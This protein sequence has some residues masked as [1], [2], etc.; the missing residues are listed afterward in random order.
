MLS[1]LFLPIMLAPGV[2]LYF[3]MFH[4]P[5]A[6]FWIDRSTVLG[7]PTQVMILAGILFPFVL[8]LW[9]FWSGNWRRPVLTAAFVYGTCFVFG[10][11]GLV[12]SYTPPE[13]RMINLYGTKGIDV[14]CNGVHLG[15]LPLKI[16]VEE[17]MAKVP[18]WT[19]PPEQRWYSDADHNQRRTTW[20]P[21]DDFRKE[22]FE[23]S[24]E[25][26]ATTG[27]RNTSNT[28]RAI[29]ARQEALNKHDAECRY[30]WSYRSGDTQMAFLRSENAYYFN[31]PFEKQ[32]SYYSDCGSAFSPSVGFHAQLL[33]DVLPELTPEQKADWDKHV[34]KHWSLLSTSLHRAL[35]QA[36]TRH[37]RDNNEGL[38]ELYASALH[39]TARLHYGLS[40]PPTEEECR[41][42][43][44]D[45][46]QESI[47]DGAFRFN[48]DRSS[49]HM[50]V[51]NI[52]LLPTDIKEPMRRPLTEQWKKD[53]Y[54]FE[55]GWAPVAYLIW[56]DKHPDHFADFAR[57]SATTG[58]A[59][60][61]LLENE[62]PGTVALFKTLLNRRSLT[63]ILQGQIYRYPDQ[64]NLYSLVNNPLAEPVFR[65]YIIKAL[66][67]PDHNESTRSNVEQAVINATWL[68]TNRNDT[69]KDELA[70][71]VASLPVPASSKSLALRTLRIRQD[72]VLTFADQ[73]QQAAG[74]RVL[75]ET[76]LTLDDVVKWFADNPEGSLQ[77]FIEEQEEN[78]LVSNLSDGRRNRGVLS[79]SDSFDFDGGIVVSQRSDGQTDGGLPS[80]FV[81]ALLRSDMP[82]GD[83]RVRELI[84]RI[85]KQNHEHVEM[86]VRNEYGAFNFQRQN[87]FATDVGS[88][89]L[90]EYIL[91]LYLSPEWNKNISVDLAFILALC[92][93]PK[94]GEILEKWNDMVSAANRPRIERCF[95]IWRTRNAFRQMK[96]EIFQ[97]LIAGR[98]VPDDLLFPQPA[99]VWKDGQYVQGE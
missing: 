98:M 11:F 12:E 41:K 49:L 3:L 32:S 72:N 74:R 22:R 21:W 83:P 27:N 37:R 35:S 89:Y 68:R 79:S 70:A 69:D 6:Y 71:W 9:M 24:K 45:W 62:A 7:L 1:T 82:E 28:P 94:A 16:R 40:D 93:S 5:G 43:L 33:A 56:Q 64:I 97:D 17:L 48:W 42:L 67:D 20:L 44:A 92:E 73:L 54:R 58:K 36:T 19:T 53:K 78:I 86:A 96:M 63:P 77:K 99:W 81:R 18:E 59:R 57:W 65:E 34:L 2:L 66:S 75:I 15:Q 14:Y 90:P 10:A 87:A 4:S 84:R 23:A 38:A 85:W 55:D 39:S 30:W 26:F 46:V 47:D 52:S 95:E 51:A 29:K 50:P 80:L 60:V 91:D 8:W 13:K 25:L 76:E 31:Q 61:A 88:I